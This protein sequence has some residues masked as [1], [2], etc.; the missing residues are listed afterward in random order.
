M[1]HACFV[2]S[3]FARA[4]INGIDTV[5]GAGAARCA[6]RVHRRGPQPGRQG[7]LARGRGQGHPRH[8]AS[9]AGRGRGEVRRRPGRPRGRREPLRRRGR[10]RAGRRRLRAAA[11]D[12]RLPQ[13]VDSDVVVHE[14]YP[15][16]VAGG[17]GG[18]PPDEETV[19]LRRARRRRRTHLP[20]DVRAGA[21]GDARHGRRMGVRHRRTDHLGVDADAARTARVRRPAARASRPRA[22]GSSCA[23]PAVASAR[24]SSRCARTCASCSPRARCPPR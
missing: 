16:N 20:A 15:D 1:L 22:S 14:A 7:G 5:G 24:R 6:R 18:V 12:R 23:T 17:M 21:D 4:T 13:A 3:P 9:A 2:R 11:R 10:R 19:R 8:P